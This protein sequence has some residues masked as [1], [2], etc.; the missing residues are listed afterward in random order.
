MVESQFNATDVRSMWLGLNAIMDF[1]GKTVSV[2]N[3]IAAFIDELNTFYACFGS[4]HA[5]PPERALDTTQDKTL[6]VSMAEMRRSFKRVN[7]HKA[8]GPDSIPGGILKA[9]AGRLAGVF[10]DIFSLSLYLSVV[11]IGV[12]IL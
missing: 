12:K 2:T 7:T 11:M 9:S 10:A 1:R 8:A 6:S 5:E 3:T 4:C